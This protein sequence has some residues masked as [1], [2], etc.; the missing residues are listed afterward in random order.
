M[1]APYG[2]FGTPGYE[3]LLA[4]L[5]AAE[6]SHTRYERT[7]RL[8]TWNGPWSSSTPCSTGRR[9]STSAAPP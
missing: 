6:E 3:Q 7:G 2:L 9:T 4:V 1:S 5:G 8:L